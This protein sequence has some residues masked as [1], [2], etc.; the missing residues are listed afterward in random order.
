MEI[1]SKINSLRSKQLLI[2]YISALTILWITTYFTPNFN[3]SSF[4][5]LI[6][7]AFIIIILD[8]LV[9]TITGI[10]D[11][12]LYRAIVSLVACAVI[13]Y[14]TQFL[15]PGYYISIFSTII[16]ATIYGVIQF[17]LPNYAWKTKTLLYNTFGEI[18]C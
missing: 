17:N 12:P 10:H 16:A 2:R 6:I 1:K 8:Y 11:I 3:M 14:M 18:K 15:V 7:S 4:P 13:L 5:G 9:A